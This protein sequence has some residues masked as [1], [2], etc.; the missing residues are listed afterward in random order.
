ML[1]EGAGLVSVPRRDRLQDKEYIFAESVNNDN[2]TLRSSYVRFKN[3][4]SADQ[5]GVFSNWG[6]Q[7]EPPL[8]FP[9]L[10]QYRA[11]QTGCDGDDPR[12]F[13]M[14]W[15]GRF[16]DKPYMAILS[17][18]YTQNLGL[19]LERTNVDPN[20]CRPQLW[21]WIYQSSASSEAKL[22]RDLESN[23]WAA[24]FLHPRFQD[25]VHFK[26]WD[27]EEQLDSLPELRK[28]WRHYGHSLVRARRSAHDD[29][30]LHPSDDKHHGLIAR[31]PPPLESATPAPV[32]A[33]DKPSV[34]L[35]DLARFVLCHR[36][37]GIYLDAD[38]LLL[39]DWEELWNWRGAFAYRWSRLD[40]YNT[41]V[42]RLHR[43]SALGTL[44]VRTALRNALDFHPIRVTR[45]VKDAGVEA[46]LMRLPDALFDPAWLGTERF[47]LERPPEPFFERW[48]LAIL[49]AGGL[50]LILV[51]LAGS[52]TFS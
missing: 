29:K 16:T 34:Q 28:E 5:S 3:N 48:V 20:V 46:L 23:P 10:P 38:T 9:P 36:F 17:F 1:R 47:Q 41:A 32:P 26:I 50:V 6:T 15:T 24:P 39:R 37:G 4:D 11:Q 40:R 44:L 43:G 30:P 25:A 42:L 2:S 8:H 35:S 21:I 19:H 45:Y 52:K 18:L 49:A 51:L 27:T 33:Y 12:I 22:R 14:F 31:A 7:D 13:H